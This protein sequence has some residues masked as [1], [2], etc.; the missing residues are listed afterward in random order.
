MY[1]NL[2]QRN[3]FMLAKSKDCPFVI[4]HFYRPGHE[5]HGN[6]KPS[7]NYLGDLKNSLVKNLG[8][9]SLHL[10]LAKCRIVCCSCCFLFLF[11]DLPFFSYLISLRISLNIKKN[12]SIDAMRI[13][14]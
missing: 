4:D 14:S 9:D 11:L 13:T 6:V 1:F 8:F 2:L 5:S 3:Y 12:T 10:L 7:K